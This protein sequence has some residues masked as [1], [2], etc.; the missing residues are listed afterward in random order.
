MLQDILDFSDILPDKK[1]KKLDRK[2][3]GSQISAPK[4]SRKKRKRKGRGHSS[5][6]GKTA[7]RGENG[8]KSRSGYSYTAGFEGGQMPLHRRLPKRGFRSINPSDFQLVNL[9]RIEKA[10][11]KGEITPIVLK[12][13][14][15]IR[16]AKKPV[17]ILGTGDI[18]SGITITADAFTSSAK[19]KIATAGGNCT[20]RNLKEE[21]KKVKKD[22]PA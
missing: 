13:E 5:G 19:D 14:G 22:K 21:L 3:E 11:L 8:Q 1:R 17:K 2:I 18:K 9:Y 15:L 12:K 20:V 16:S 7:S 6:M 4:N 10:G